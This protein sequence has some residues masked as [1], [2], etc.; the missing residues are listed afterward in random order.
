MPDGI[1]DTELHK[2]ITETVKTRRRTVAAWIIAAVHEI[3]L[4]VSVDPGQAGAN[5]VVYVGYRLDADGRLQHVIEL[6]RWT[7]NELTEWRNHGALKWCPGR[8]RGCNH[9][10]L[11]GSDIHEH[12]RVCER[13]HQARR[14]AGR[15]VEPDVGIPH[16]LRGG[17]HSMKMR[18]VTRR[19]AEIDGTREAIAWRRMKL[20]QLVLGAEESTVGLGFKAQVV[21]RGS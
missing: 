21:R 11:A 18:D 17:S 16:V 3:R 7:A 4:S 19:L 10:A 15:P 9:R 8:T 12:V 13:A 2:L 20:A 1:F 6:L 5:P 14:V